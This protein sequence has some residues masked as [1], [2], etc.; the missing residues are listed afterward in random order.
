MQLSLDKYR[1]N[2]FCKKRRFFTPHPSGATG[3]SVSTSCSKGA[4]GDEPKLDDY[5]RNEK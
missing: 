2:I 1:T 5:V 3:F 4:S